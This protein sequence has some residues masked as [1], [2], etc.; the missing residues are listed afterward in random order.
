MKSGKL[1]ALADTWTA[2]ISAYPELSTA[3]EQGF[4]EVRIATGPACTRRTARRTPCS[5]R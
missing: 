4:P 1:K 2:R 3:A 5:T